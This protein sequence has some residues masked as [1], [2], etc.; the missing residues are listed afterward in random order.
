MG[1]AE[2]LALING[3][4]PF[5]APAEV[6]IE[7]VVGALKGAGAMSDDEADTDLRNLIGEAFAAKAEAD[8]AAAGLDPQ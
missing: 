3:L 5:V 8:R 7:H 2:I 4:A 6:T 1:I